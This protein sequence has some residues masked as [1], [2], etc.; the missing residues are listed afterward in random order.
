M[1]ET[2]P[3]R[4]QL[5]KDIDVRYENYE[6][7]KAKKL[8]ISGSLADVLDS[9]DIRIKVKQEDLKN[10]RAE[11]IRAYIDLSTI[12]GPGK[13]TREISVETQ[14]GKVL[15][16]NPSEVKLIVYDYV[17]RTVPVNV[18]ISGNVPDGY[19]ASEPGITPNVVY[20]SGASIDVEKVASANCSIELSG[21]TSGYNKSVKV[22]LL[23]NDGAAIDSKLFGESVPSVIVTLDVLA[24][25]TVSVDAI[26][27]VL[28]QGDLAPGYEITDIWALPETADIIGEKSTLDGISKIKL[29]PY[30]VSG[31]T[32]D[33]VVPLDYNPIEGVSVLST[34]KAQISISIREIAETKEFGSVDIQTKNISRGLEAELDINDVDVTVIVGMVKLSALDKSEIVPYID[35]E[36][37]E[38]GVYNLGI[39]F[40]ILE[41]FTKDNFTPGQDTVA[42]TIRN[43]H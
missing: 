21:L 34:Q 32:E 10:L 36:G 18:D 8:T 33:V 41:G 1:A 11:N 24:K 31:A 3:E 7:L 25:K 23:D 12:N 27:S 26:G 19:Y 22:E 30:S 40:E 39:Q 43:A 29:V 16:K 28:G 17:T 13:Y 14:F 6:E 15:D 5:M 42:V 4:E 20:I 2:N 9:I 35:L 38:P 37:L